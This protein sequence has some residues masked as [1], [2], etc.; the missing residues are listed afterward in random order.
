MIE[1]LEGEPIK[2]IGQSQARTLIEAVAGNGGR[3]QRR[4]TSQ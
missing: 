2:R 1:E 4:I 3:P